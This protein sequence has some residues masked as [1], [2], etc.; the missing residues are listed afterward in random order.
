VAQGLSVTVASADWD[1]PGVPG[2]EMRA[3]NGRYAATTLVWIPAASLTEFADAI[4]GFP[5][6]DPDDRSFE[7]GHRR[8]E[9]C[10]QFRW[11]PGFLRLRFTYPDDHRAARVDAYFE[12]D[13]SDT[14]VAFAF[15][16][17][18]ASVDSFVLELRNMASHEGGPPV[19]SV[20]TL[21]ASD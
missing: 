19:G 16:V 21:G 8:G 1:D 13:S 3:W 15:Q 4:D 2:V 6:R 9:M 14:D 12:D 7:F 18:A 5:A 20:A 11:A 17:E 10:G